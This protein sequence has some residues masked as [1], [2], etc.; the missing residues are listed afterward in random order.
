M[1][2]SNDVLKEVN[3]SP[4]ARDV[5]IKMVRR[6]TDSIKNVFVLGFWIL[7]I[8]GA[9]VTYKVYNDDLQ[10]FNVNIPE[11]PQLPNIPSCPVQVCD[12]KC[13]TCPTCPVNTCQCNFPNQLN[14]KITNS[15]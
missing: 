9:V 3:N 6:S 15:S 1:G 13:S 4:Q 10:L 12:T 11:C 14:V 7:V 8:C 5:G 2:I